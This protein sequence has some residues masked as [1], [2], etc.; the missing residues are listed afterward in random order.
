MFLHGHAHFVIRR[1][2]CCNNYGPGS[3]RE[4]PANK[5]N[6]PQEL[7]CSYKAQGLNPDPKLL[8][9]SEGRAEAMLDHLSSRV[10][11]HLAKQQKIKRSGSSVQE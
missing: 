1:I 10:S 3:L 9:G 5:R 2:R 6:A 11:S 7:A 4:L 8:A